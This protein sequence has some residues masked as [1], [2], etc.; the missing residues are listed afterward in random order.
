MHNNQLTQK[1]FKIF[2]FS[3]IL[4]SSH[5]NL[6]MFRLQLLILLLITQLA[7]SQST[8]SG[9]I[10]DGDFN[11]PLPFANVLIKETGEGGT[12]DFD[13]KFSIEVAPGNYT[14]IFSFVGYQTLEVNDI[15]ASSGDVQDIEITMTSAAEG[16]EEVIVSISARNNTIESVLA[17]QKPKNQLVY[18]MGYH[19]NLLKILVPLIWHQP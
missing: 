11:E 19:L 7:F 13:G 3:G 14:L 16:L 18:W 6:I 15:D 12:T 4:N 1:L 9:S 8:I 10:I 2:I 17:I 5:F